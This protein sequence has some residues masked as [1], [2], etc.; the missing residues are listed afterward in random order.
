MRGVFQGW[1]ESQDHLGTLAPWENQAAMVQLVKMERAAYQ[2]TTGI[3]VKRVN[4]GQ[5]VSVVLQVKEVDRGSP[6]VEVTTPRMH[7]Q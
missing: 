4:Q 7:S 2:G 5:Q 3:Q 1:E 6:A